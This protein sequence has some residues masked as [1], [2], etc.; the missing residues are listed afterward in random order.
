MLVKLRLWGVQCV[1]EMRPQSIYPSSREGFFVNPCPIE[2]SQVEHKRFWSRIIHI[3]KDRN[4]LLFAEKDLCDGQ[5]IGL[6]EYVDFVAF[7]E[8]LSRREKILLA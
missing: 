1:W 6:F 4:C 5:F 2:R 8:E 3:L 7:G